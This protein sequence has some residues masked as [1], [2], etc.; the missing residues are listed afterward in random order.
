MKNKTPR[1]SVKFQ[2]QADDNEGGELNAELVVPQIRKS[3]LAL[4]V[5][6]PLVLYGMFHQGLTTDAFSTMVKGLANLVLVQLVYGYLLATVLAGDP[7]KKKEK[8]LTNIPL[9]VLS[10]TAAAGVLA[11]GL[12][13]CLILFGA[14]LHSHVPETYVLSYHLAMILAQPLM[15]VYRLDYEKFLSLFQLECIY[16]TIFSHPTLSSTFLGILGTWLGVIPIPLDWDRPWQQ[17]P[18]TLLVGGYIG[19]FLGALLAL[20]VH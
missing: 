8:N 10:A 15:I 9:L 3:V 12:F 19:A 2:T 20:F 14:P 17:W 13:A 7:K 1:K 6:L 16:R 11:N 4:P 5:Q 18:I